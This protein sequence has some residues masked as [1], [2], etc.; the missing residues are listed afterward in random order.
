MPGAS[1]RFGPT[2]RMST[3]VDTGRSERRARG[4]EPGEVLEEVDQ[5]LLAQVVGMVGRKAKPMGQTLSEAGGDRD[6]GILLVV[7]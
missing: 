5:Q 2:L 3:R 1:G 7:M 4:V 6:G